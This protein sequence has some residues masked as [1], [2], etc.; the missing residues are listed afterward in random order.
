VIHPA[1]RAK[2]NDDRVMALTSRIEKSFTAPPTLA[3]SCIALIS[4]RS[5]G[6]GD[7]TARLQPDFNL[8]QPASS[9]DS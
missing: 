7:R 4:P 8:D 5:K 6:L 2:L 1:V 9:L 3:D